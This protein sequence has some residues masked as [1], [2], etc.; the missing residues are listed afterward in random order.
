MTGKKKTQ[1]HFLEGDA[2]GGESNGTL[3]FLCTSTV[4][5]LMHKIQP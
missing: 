3:G 1:E 2:D 5:A 4:G